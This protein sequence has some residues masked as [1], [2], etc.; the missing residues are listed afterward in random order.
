MIET[1]EYIR[2]SEFCKRLGISK[3]ALQQ[4]ERRGRVKIEIY[5]G[6]RRIEWHENRRS[7]IE[8]SRQ[9]YRY[10]TMAVLKRKNGKRSNGNQESEIKKKNGNHPIDLIEDPDD[11]DGDFRPNM[12]RLEAESVKQVYLAKQAKLKFLKEA[13]ILIESAVVQKEWEEIAIR[14]QKAMVSIPDRVAEMFASIDDAE[15]IRADLMSEITHA[16]SSMQYRVKTEDSN[17]NI[18]EFVEEKI[19][20]TN[21]SQ[22]S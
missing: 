21:D 11:K 15:K 2:Q 12:G 7:Y 10:K 14:V 8:S 1:K 4:A 13:G 5:N 16:L 22:N 9:P 18:K 6:N 20:E 17:D 19:E 3:Q